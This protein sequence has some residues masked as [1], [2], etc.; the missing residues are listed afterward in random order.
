MGVVVS[1]HLLWGWEYSS[2]VESALQF[3]ALDL[4]SQHQ[5][6]KGKNKKQR[7]LFVNP[8]W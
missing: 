2:V 6:G 1:R 3:K 7:L 5:K 8:T 4:I